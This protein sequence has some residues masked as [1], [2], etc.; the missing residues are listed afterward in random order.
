MFKAVGVVLGIIALTVAVVAIGWGIQ[1]FTAPFRG[2][3]DAREQI[4]ADGSFRIAA[5]ETFFNQ[6]ASV[7]ALEGQLDQQFELRK[8]EHDGQSLRRINNVIAGI[9]GQRFTAISKY[10]ADSHK[11]YTVAQFKSSD[12]PFEIPLVTYSEGDTKTQCSG[13]GY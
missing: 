8:V 2:S 9:Q 4:Q 6:C 13:F 7:Q 1:W 3:L 11:G 12:L 5:Y 10:N